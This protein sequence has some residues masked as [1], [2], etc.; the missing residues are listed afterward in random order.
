MSHLFM[1]IVT[2]RNVVHSA[3]KVWKQKKEI[4]CLLMIASDYTGFCLLKAFILIYAV[5][6]IIGEKRDYLAFALRKS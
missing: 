5:S 3:R 4:W 1:H 6:E 2:G